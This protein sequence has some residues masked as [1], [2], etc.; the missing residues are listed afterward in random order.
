MQ[1][2]INT[3]EEET[4]PNLRIPNST[5]LYRIQNLR[6]L[7]MRWVFQVNAL[8][9]NKI[10]VKAVPTR[11]YRQYF[12]TYFFNSLREINKPHVDFLSSRN[13]LRPTCTILYDQWLH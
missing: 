8:I 12:T 4:Q 7:L 13:P 10:M 1:V 5:S 2:L 3:T 9:V 11:S 6:R